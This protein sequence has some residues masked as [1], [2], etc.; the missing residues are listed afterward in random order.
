VTGSLIGDDST[1]QKM[2]GKKIEGIGHHYST[3]AGSTIRGH[4]LLQSLYVLLGRRC[5]LTPQLY[6]QRK[7]CV[8]EGV[9]FRGKVELMVEMIRD[10]V[11]LA[12]THTH[13][14]LD[15]WYSAKVIWKTAR[16]RG[17]DITTGLKGNRL[18]RVR[19]KGARGGWQWSSL[20][21]YA[22]AL[23]DDDYKQVV[24][25]RQ[26]GEGRT[27]Y[28]YVATKTLQKLGRVQL[29]IVR[30]KRDGK[31]TASHLDAATVSG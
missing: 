14:L 28:V 13:I 31:L 27:V 3:T 12:D 19:D 7:T 29:M 8:A 21:D 4:S 25:P 30:E 11:P 17:F 15:A 26:D 24:W 20:D 18:V 1:C 6:R 5:P 9:A 22:S 23:T 2:R 10:F 16:E